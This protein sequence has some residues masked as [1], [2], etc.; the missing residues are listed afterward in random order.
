MCTLYRLKS[1]TAEIARLFDAEPRTEWAPPAAFH[2]DRP[3]PVVGHGKAGR[4]LADARWGVPPPP[5][6]PGG[7]PVVNVRNLASPFWRGALARPALRC[8]VP[9]DDFCEWTDTPDPE[10]G[11]KR[12]VF[13]GLADGTPFAFAGLIRPAPSASEDPPRFAFLTC[14]ANAVVAPVHAKA[15]PVLLMP[16]QW[17]PWLDGAPAEAFQHPLDSNRLRIVEGG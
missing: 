5:S 8:L 1:T 13:F 14:A 17:G 12:K 9:A 3:A 15:M 2:P 7:R 11:R 6:A 10:T 4:V 16:E